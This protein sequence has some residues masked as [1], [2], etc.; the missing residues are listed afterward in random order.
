[1]LKLGARR[2]FQS[3]PSSR[4]AQDKVA[5][6]LAGPEPAPDG[7]S[8]DRAMEDE[9]VGESHGDRS[10]STD[11]LVL[12]GRFRAVVFD[13][14][15]LLV[16]TEPAWTAA[17]AELLARHGG[18]SLPED[19]LETVGRSVDATVAVYAR[20]MG[21]EPARLGD[22]REELIDLFL[23]RLPGAVPMPGAADLV[24]SLAGRLPLGVASSSPRVIVREVLAAAGFDGAFNVIVT[25]DDVSRH[26][27]AA[28]PYVEAGRRLH[29]DPRH[30]VAFE[31][32]APGVI[33]ATAAGMWCV[34]VQ[35]DPRIDVCAADLILPTLELVTVEPAHAAASS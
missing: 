9:A 8:Y 21:I 12:P 14:D 23:A 35:R 3:A 11:G 31:D 20:R 16:A 22:L 24:R 34:A 25:G 6:R 17:E 4:R 13:L 28:D 26:K 2:L 7:R 27:P 19:D 18:V 15:G 33:A 32:S 1:V 10:C 5:E 29:V 30:A